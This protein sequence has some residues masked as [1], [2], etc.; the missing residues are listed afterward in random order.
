MFMGNDHALEITGID[1]I[2][3]KMYDAS[4]CTILKVRHVKGLMK[5]LLTI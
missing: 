3:L 4:F 1:T 5:N 2:K